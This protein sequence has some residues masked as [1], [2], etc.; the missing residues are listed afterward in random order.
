MTCAVQ[1]C[2]RSG[3]KGACSCGS[4]IHIEIDGSPIIGGSHVMPARNGDT[5]ISI[6]TSREDVQM[7]NTAKASFRSNRQFPCLIVCAGPIVENVLFPRRNASVDPR[8][9]RSRTIPCYKSR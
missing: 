5:H 7:Q 8:L 9:N 3:R 6:T 1:H 2:V 4:A